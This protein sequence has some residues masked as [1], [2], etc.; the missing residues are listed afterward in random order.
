MTPAR[1]LTVRLAEVDT[2]LNGFR[3]GHGKNQRSSR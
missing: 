3:L 2:A 1:H